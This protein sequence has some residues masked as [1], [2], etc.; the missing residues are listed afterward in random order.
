M[1]IKMMSFLFAY[2]RFVLF[3]PN[4]QLSF[5]LMF[6]CAFKTVFVFIFL[7]AFYVFYACQVFSQKGIKLPQY[8]HLIYYYIITI[9]FHHQNTFPSSQYIFI[10]TIHFHYNNTFSLSQ[11]IISLSQY[12]LKLI[13][14]HAL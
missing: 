9:Y 7:R 3:V 1:G 12:T 13:F 10:I 4:K 5:S 6:L 11:Y 14:F 8:H 2:V